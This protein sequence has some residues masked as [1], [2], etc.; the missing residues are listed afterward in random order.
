VS[1]L[2]QELTQSRFG[3]GRSVRR[4]NSHHVEASLA[5]GLVQRRFDSVQVGQKSRSA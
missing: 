1:A 2:G 3:K 5:R 4:C